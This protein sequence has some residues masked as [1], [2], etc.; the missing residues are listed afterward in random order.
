MNDRLNFQS[1][2]AVRAPQYQRWNIP[3]QCWSGAEY[4]EDTILVFFY[5]HTGEWSGR[6]E[7]NQ[8]VHRDLDQAEINSIRT[9]CKDLMPGR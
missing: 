5:P 8:C 4:G 6:T 2:G 7:M 3:A 1:A 9:E